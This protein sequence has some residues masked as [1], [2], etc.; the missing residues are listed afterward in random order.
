VPRLRS[1]EWFLL[2]Y[3][4]Y[5]A[6]VSPFFVSAWRPCLVA[7]VVAAL[8]LRL[9]R[10][11]SWLRDLLPLPL[12]L[13]AF[14]EM[15]WFT[16]LVRNPHWEQ[17]LIVWDRTLFDRYGLSAAVESAG[18]LMPM[19]LEL[20]YMLVYLVAPVALWAL[21]A[22]RHRDRVNQFWLA[23]LVGTLGAYALF[24]YFL[25]DSPRVAFPGENL[26]HF[27]TFFRRV[28]L[29]IASHYDIHSSVFPSAHVSSAL[30]A[31]WG[32]LETIPE[33]RWIGWTMAVY[34]LCVAVA[35][36][37]GR[38]HYAADAVAGIAISFLG[39]A[40][41]VYRNSRG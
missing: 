5:V 28:N 35:T 3:F 26:P 37:Y 9:A 6:C 31:A 8:V 38:Y 36:V 34:G 24:P 21:I 17:T 19:F 14:W 11:E 22:N 13:A 27:V 20:C 40:A 16:P 30:S 25:S 7:I 33:R 1:S 4:A 10:G 39:L 41:M 29:W 23:Y 12:T 18:H 15:D 2:I 32:L